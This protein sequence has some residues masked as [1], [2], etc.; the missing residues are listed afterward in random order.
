[1]QRETYAKTTAPHFPF[2]EE[3]ME[4]HGFVIEPPGDSTCSIVW[5]NIINGAF[6]LTENH[7][8]KASPASAP[9][10]ALDQIRIRRWERDITTYQAIARMRDI[11]AQLQPLIEAIV[12]DYSPNRIIIHGPHA[13]NDATPDDELGLLIIKE[14]SERPLYRCVSV[15]KVLAGLAD[16][17][18]LDILVL[19]EN[20]FRT[21][22]EA[23][24][25]YLR[26]ILG[27]GVELYAG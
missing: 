20:E 9:G 11:S 21:A 8:T 17:P 18:P 2:S 24:D 12:R 1:M 26:D 6:G 19:T 23:N 14:T 3:S 22:T 15:R 25:P 16:S 7:R 10:Q 5:P 27:S 4:K 13:T